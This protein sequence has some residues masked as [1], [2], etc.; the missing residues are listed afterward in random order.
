MAYEVS[1]RSFLKG[2][3]T[4]TAA[5]AASGL[6]A[7]CGDS[8]GGVAVANY[9]VKSEGISTGMIDPDHYYIQP[10]LVIKCEKLN[11]FQWFKNKNFG[12]IFE[13][14]VAGSNEK[15][16]VENKNTKFDTTMVK[17]EEVTCMPQFYTTDKT[18][19]EQL[20]SGEKK[21]MMT[22]KFGEKDKNKGT[23]EVDPSTG[24]IKYIV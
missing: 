22:I 2:A 14:Y 15:L 1:R 9:T 16:Y 20:K 18:L 12:D 10:K 17:G 21:L 7:G 19:W 23:F 5:V 4:L 8:K 24:K 13:A 6:L 11:V 3:V